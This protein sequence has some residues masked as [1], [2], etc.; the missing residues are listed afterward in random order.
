[1]WSKCRRL[2]GAAFA[3]LMIVAGPLAAQSSSNPCLGND[4]RALQLRPRDEAAKRPDLVE[5]RRALR[6]A[7]THRDVD[8]V[9]KSST[10]M[11]RLPSAATRVSRISSVSTSAATGAAWIFG[12]SSPGRS[13]SVVRSW[14][15][16]RLRHPMSTPL[17]PKS[18]TPSIASPSSALPS[19][20]EPHRESA[21]RRLHA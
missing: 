7:V 5:F 12:R 10:P 20:S 21:R 6:N 11:S 15:R 13:R 16:R 18:W 19:V 8:A 14:H 1:M 9:V 17:G 2:S 3:L 4:G